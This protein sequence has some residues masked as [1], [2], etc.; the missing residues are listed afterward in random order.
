ME[1]SK[2]LSEQ[3]SEKLSEQLG[4]NDASCH[5]YAFSLSFIAEEA[6]EA[7]KEGRWED[8]IHRLFRLSD[9]ANFLLFKI[10][11]SGKYKTKQ[12]TTNE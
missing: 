9:S 12:E 6:T 3:L 2:K 7:I 10:A 8:A 5:A 1:H 4:K 11:T